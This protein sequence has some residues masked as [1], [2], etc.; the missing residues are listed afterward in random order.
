MYRSRQETG[1]QVRG[2]GVGDVAGISC[3]LWRGKSTG[4][5][6]LGAWGAP[7]CLFSESEKVKL[8]VSLEGLIV[9][10]ASGP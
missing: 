6:S 8:T 9:V 3:C 1:K 7:C 10:G 4:C 2:R 5:T